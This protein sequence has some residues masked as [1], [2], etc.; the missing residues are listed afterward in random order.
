MNQ[1]AKNSIPLK[2]K[3]IYGAI[4]II[5][6]PLLFLLCV[7]IGLRLAGVG[8]IT[9]F[10]LQKTINEEPAYITNWRYGWRFF[11]QKIARRPIDQV[12]PVEKGENVYRVFTLGGSAA[13]G[14]PN[15]RY[16]FQRMLR[17]LLQE[18]YPG[19]R[20][21]FINAAMT[22][23]N[24]H[25]VLEIAKDCAAYKPDLMIVYMGN[26]EVVGPFGAGSVNRVVSP[27]LAMIR[28]NLFFQTFRLGQAMDAAIASLASAGEQPTT[29]SGMKMF[30]SLVRSDSEAMETIY[31]HFEQNLKDVLCISGN[32]QTIVSTVGVNLRDCP[33]FASVHRVDLTNVEKVQWNS[34]YEKGI[35]LQ[36]E[37]KEAAA[38]DSYLAADEVDDRHANL[39]YR[40][41]QLL[42]A[43]NN[44][45]LARKRYAR[46]R[47]LDAL[48]FRADTRINEIIR[49]QAQ[50]KEEAGIYFIDYAARVAEQ[51][52]NGIPGGKHFY[53][54]VHMN[55]E[56]NY[57]LAR[58][59][60]EQVQDL[61]PA[62]V[63]DEAKAEAFWPTQETCADRLAYTL[64]DEFQ[65]NQTL[66]QRMVEPPFL[67]QMNHDEKIASI[68]ESMQ[69][70]F[71]TPQPM[72]IAN[73]IDVYTEALS[74]WPD[75]YFLRYFLAE[76][77]IK[78]KEYSRA[79][80][81]LE[82]LQ[83][84][85]P[86]NASIPVKLGDMHAQQGKTDTA[87]QMYDRALA[88]RPNYNRAMY[89]KGVALA[90][91]KRYD[92]A[93]ELYE[94]F[95]A[96]YPDHVSAHINLAMLYG[97][98]G[99]KEKQLQHLKQAVEYGPHDK[100]A[101]N[102]YGVALAQRGALEEAVQYFKR[103]L[104]VDPRYRSAKQNLQKAFHKLQQ[105]GRAEVD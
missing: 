38:L 87:V 37:G 19:V 91:G 96:L 98:E 7:E 35:A 39:Q 30:N 27:S 42:E 100:T 29:W 20:F 58:L 10:F 36:G 82:K 44:H 18:R 24:S 50:G 47:D 83:E 65:I 102:H 23:I 57:L 80:E 60:A 66:L 81:H 21:E 9:D 52:E 64:W 101:L 49:E 55:F 12:M 43:N 89:F 13:Q 51:S 103:A 77:L 74:Q 85:Y 1:N 88:L 69:A 78:G 61:V 17:V 86:Y 53:E 2:R 63:Q 56:G 25:T 16:G 46:A 11:P 33:P 28:W 34:L 72:A 90:N 104:R 54:H 45:A 70:L 22:G 75:D 97:N 68:H 3:L 40:I 26:N 4:A 31:G 32:T 5:G 8:Y 92:K 6:I 48:R 59:L 99:K 94:R 95:L 73:A 67:F 84:Q 15:P 62:W 93:K 71:K 76:V 105:A 14:D 79:E 41:A